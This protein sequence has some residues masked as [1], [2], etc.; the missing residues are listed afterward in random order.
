MNAIPPEPIV[1]SA[2]RRRCIT[3][4]LRRRESIGADYHVLTFDVPA[5]LDARPGQFVM[6]RGATWGSAP[7]L[8]RPMSLL[9]AGTEPSILIRVVG[10]GTGRLACAA[11][12]ERFQLVGPLGNWWPAVA[13]HRSPLLAAG[14]VGIAPLLFLARTLAAAG[15]RAVATYGARSERDL[16]LRDALAEV[17]ELTVC[18]EDG[19][20]GTCGLVTDVL[21]RTLR[22]EAHVF[23]CGPEPMLAKVAELCAAADVPCEASL[24]APMACGF[25]VCLG[26]AVPTRDGQYLYACTEGPCVD[27]RRIDW[28]RVR[29]AKREGTLSRNEAP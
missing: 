13:P 19:S 4:P 7:L 9:S 22:P 24:E 26:C 14:G 27:A 3:V 15:T 11:P 18:T 29:S 21:Q 16:P 23:T 1:R 17:A 25:G 10:D 20:S 8:P 28:K 6:I 12:G 5:G 2:P